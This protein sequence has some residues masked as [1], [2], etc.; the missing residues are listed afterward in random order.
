[1]SILQTHPSDYREQVA[2]AP[3]FCFFV[4]PLSKAELLTRLYKKQKCQPIGWHILHLL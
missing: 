1:M 2:N 4:H 3:C